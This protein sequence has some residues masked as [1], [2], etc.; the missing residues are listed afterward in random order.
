MKTSLFL[1]II[2]VLSYSCSHKQ[3]YFHPSYFTGEG[4]SDLKDLSY[5][6]L[7]E[8]L[9]KKGSMGGGLYSISLTP[10]T[11]PLL[12]KKAIAEG[13]WKNLRPEEIVELQ[14]QLI[15]KYATGQMCFEYRSEILRFV[16]ASKTADWRLKLF[17]DLVSV[18]EGEIEIQEQGAQVYDLSWQ[19][20]L[21][22]VVESHVTKIHDKIPQWL[23]SGVSCLDRIIP[24]EKGFAVKIIAPYINFPFPSDL[25]LD[26]GKWASYSDDQLKDDANQDPIP[27]KSS[28]VPTQNSQ[29]YRGW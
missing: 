26:W 21:P 20:P 23:Q 7:Y 12:E 27:S 5:S 14:R 11:P 9:T 3:E 1:F 25:R 10:L 2:L 24:L 19:S 8:R 29:R 4:E 13:S 17:T 28:K 6:E 18:R 16:Q 15:S 22:Q